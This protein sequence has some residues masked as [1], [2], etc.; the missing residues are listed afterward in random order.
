MLKRSVH[1]YQDVVGL[2]APL[3][4]GAGLS[5]VTSSTAP[6]LAA[7]TETTGK[8]RGFYPLLRSLFSGY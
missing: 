5:S 2:L 1:I 8:S 3:G 4:I 7:A 6:P